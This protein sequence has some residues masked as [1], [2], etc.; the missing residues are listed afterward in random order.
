MEQIR[1]IRRSSRAAGAKFLKVPERRFQRQ[2]AKVKPRA[3]VMNQDRILFSNP[4]RSWRLCALGVE[5]HEPLGI[6][7][8]L[9][10]ILATEFFTE[11]M[12][13]E[14]AIS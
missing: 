3:Q 9:A 2:G 13:D 8:A 6:Q 1:N 11:V 4:W 10:K 14:K 5:I 12:C 7:A